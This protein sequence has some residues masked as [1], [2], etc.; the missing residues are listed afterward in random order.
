M[1]YYCAWGDAKIMG[2]SEEEGYEFSVS[3]GREKRRNRVSNTF[4]ETSSGAVLPMSDDADRQFWAED[5]L[6]NSSESR[7]RLTT[8]R[9]R[10]RS[11]SYRNR[12]ANRSRSFARNSSHSSSDSIDAETSPK[13]CKIRKYCRCWRQKLKTVKL[14]SVNTEK[15][16]STSIGERICTMNEV[17]FPECQT[18]SISDR[19]ST[20]L[21]IENHQIISSNKNNHKRASDVV[22]AKKIGLQ[23]AFK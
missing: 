8:R 23:K 7:Q 3:D 18:A 16:S 2:S 22:R 4:G 1:G 21:H 6:S 10:R 15:E 19:K 9:K 13:A 20:D 11:V 12:T 5:E 14:Q 17:V